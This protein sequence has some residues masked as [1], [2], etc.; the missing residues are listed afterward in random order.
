M[1]KDNAQVEADKAIQQGLDNA[2]KEWKVRVMSIVEEICRTQREFTSDDVRSALGDFY[3]SGTHDPRAL[4]GLMRV[5]KKEKLC[6]PTG[7]HVPSKFTHGHL[8]QVWRSL[9]FKE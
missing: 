2:K 7:F 9:I 1:E 4:G 3:S 5:A 8:H 6:E